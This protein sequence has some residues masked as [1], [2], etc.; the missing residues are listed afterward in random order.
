MKE[1]GPWVVSAEA[2]PTDRSYRLMDL[3]EGGEYKFRV[4]AETHLG[5][6]YGLE[7]TE[8]VQLKRSHGALRVILVLCV[9]K[10]IHDIGMN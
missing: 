2:R 8:P 6:G 1:A 4:A 3:V 7:S 9:F 10:C 5:S